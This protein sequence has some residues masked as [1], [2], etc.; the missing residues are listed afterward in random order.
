MR[1]NTQKPLD[2][3]TAR[4]ILEKIVSPLVAAITITESK[5]T[6]TPL[7]E[8]EVPVVWTPVINEDTNE[9]SVI[10]SLIVAHPDGEH[11]LVHSTTTHPMDINDVHYI[12]TE[13][14]EAESFVEGYISSKQTITVEINCLV[15]KH[16]T[17]IEIISEL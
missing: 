5:M 2:K 7:D 8:L 12:F 15:S 17:S 9:I 14:N 13:K 1:I 6:D 11:V 3:E 16:P 10:P 4:A